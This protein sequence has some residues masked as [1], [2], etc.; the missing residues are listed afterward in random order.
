MCVLRSCLSFVRS[1]SR[2]FTARPTSHSPTVASVR[3][4]RARCD[5]WLRAF[6]RVA[7][8]LDLH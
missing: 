3:V 8:R 1:Q 2:T 6:G 4:F 5:G 7:H